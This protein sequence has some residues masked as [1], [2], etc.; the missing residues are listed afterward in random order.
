M[1][2]EGVGI[3]LQK[4]KQMFE[5]KSAISKG[6]SMNEYTNPGPIENTV[7]IPVRG[8]QGS[9]QIQQV[10]GDVD[11]K[12]LADLDYFTNQLFG[13]LRVP[14]AFFGFTDDGA[15]FNGGTSLALISSR[16]AKT[17]KRMQ[18]IICQMVTDIINLYC[19]DQG[20]DNYVNNFTIRMQAPTTQEE[21]DRRD[22][23]SSKIGITN[24]I[25]NMLQD[26]DDQETKLKILKSLLS[27]IISNE[28]VIEILDKYIETL[29]TEEDN[30][31]S[32]DVSKEDMEDIDINLNDNT[33]SFRSNFDTGSSMEIPQEEPMEVTPEEGT[34]EVLSELPRPS[35]LGVG[36]M[37]TIQ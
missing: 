19:I 28:E 15:G 23:T 27:N 5:Q 37:S 11:V 12:G 14:K 32:T 33:G 6:S 2:K 4:I 34:E 36:D 30:I 35:E 16:Y 20:Q 24:D 17:I 13:A 1:Q 9:V 7:Y 18:N 31:P 8:E 22:N 3:L 26:V 25:M 29:E 21:I 10:G